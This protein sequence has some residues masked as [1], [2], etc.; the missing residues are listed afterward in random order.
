M[1]TDENTPNP[2]T[3]VQRFTAWYQE[4]GLILF[5]FF[6]PV[7]LSLWLIAMAKYFIIKLSER[8]PQ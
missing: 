7:V 3:P 6:L 5:L 4:Q 1:E 2:Q 8:K